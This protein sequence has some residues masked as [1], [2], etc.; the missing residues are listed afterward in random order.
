MTR[1][2]PR[3]RHGLGVAAAVVALD[4]LSKW[5]LPHWL[6]ADPVGWTACTPVPPLEV[7]GFFNLVLYCN[8]GVSFSM[9]HT[10]SAAGPWVL[11]L[12]ALLI[13]AGLLVWLGRTRRLW[14]AVALGLIIGGALGNVVDRLRLGAVVD[15]LDLHGWGY[16][17]PAFNLADSAITVGVILLVIDGLFTRGEGSKMRG[18]GGG[19]RPIGENSKTRS[20]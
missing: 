5:L 19:P 8:R 2:G 20:S 18:A 4:Q 7:T 11:S 17:W 1:L 10:Q 15:F 9:L 3:L 6:V 12:G 14:P 13:V 16:H